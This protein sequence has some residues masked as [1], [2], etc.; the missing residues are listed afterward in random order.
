[1]LPRRTSA[2]LDTFVLATYSFDQGGS[3][4]TEG[5]V[6]V[7]ET[8]QQDTFFHVADAIELDGGDT[9]HLIVLEGTRSMWC[10]V[11]AAGQ[12]EYCSWVSLPGYGNSWRQTFSSLPFPRVS[13]VEFAYIIRW[14]VE[15]WEDRIYVEYRDENNAWVPLLAGPP[16]N[17]FYDKKGFAHE[18]WVLPDSVLG[19]SV[20]VRFRVTTDGA[21]SDEDGFEN[22]DGAVIIDSL[23]LKDDT[24]IIDFQNFEFEPVGAH[25]TNDGHWVAGFTVDPYGDFSG[26]YPG[27]TLLQEDPCFANISSVWAFIN[28]S[29]ADYGCG[30]HPE[31]TAVPFRNADGLYL[32]NEIW[33]PPIDW[34]EDELGIP[35]PSTAASARLEFDVYRDLPVDNLVFYSYAVR[36]IKEGCPDR[37]W[38]RISA[39]VG[40][41]EAKDWFRE[42]V[43]FGHL[44]DADADQIQVSLQAL[45]LCGWYCGIYGDGDCHSHAPLFDNVRVVR[46]DT[47][48]PVWTH[49]VWYSASLELFQDN[50][51][52]DGTTTG[53]VRIDAALDLFTVG[54]P[55]VLPGD[56]A[57][58]YV[59]HPGV[60]IDDHVPGDPQS[61]PAV[62]CHIRDVSPVKS[63]ATVSGSL[64]RWPVVVSSGGWTVLRCDFSY[65]QYGSKRDGQYCVDLNDSL[66]TPGDTIEYY[67]SARDANG[68]TNFWVESVGTVETEAE[69]RSASIEVTCLPANGLNGAT[70]ILYVDDFDG[71]GAQPYYDSAF[72]ALDIVPDRYDVRAPASLTGNGPGARV[73]D[74]LAQLGCYR[75]IIWNSG[76][77]ASGLIGDGTGSPEKSDDFGMLFEFLDQHP[78]GGGLYI[79]GDHICSEW[80][81]LTGAGAVDLRGTYLQFDVV[82]EDHVVLGQPVSPP[83][84]GEPGKCFDNPSGPDTLVVHGGC[85]AIN[86]FDVL[87][88]LGASEM[89]M[90]YSGQSSYGS[91]LTQV[92]PNS[93]GDTARVVVSG[94]SYHEIH[95]DRV[96]LPVDRVKHMLSILRWLDNE[97]DDPTDVGDVARYTNELGQNVPNPFNPKTRIS[98]SIREPSHVSLRI[99]NV[100]GQLVKTLVDDVETPRSRGF[101]VEWDGRNDSG[102]LVSSGVY[103]YRLVTKDYTQTRKMVVLK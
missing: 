103:F 7:D 82:G 32:G 70:D 28:G 34:T 39:M 16:W 98:Y 97:I 35:V 80:I 1:M 81:T 12:G 53:T 76:T 84:I 13:D 59:S 78:D 23:V 72:K 42:S 20:Q 45:D 11:D 85:P 30:G 21:W 27:E 24:G 102:E 87:E 64:D 73:V 3:P 14:D 15:P 67:F 31:Q 54:N 44:I 26:L 22:T 48:G 2:V 71:G 43:E 79:S 86:R 51:A 25:R 74:V 36:S 46:I 101:V 29:T 38:E 18:N 37:E 4:S 40:Y 68:N 58:V 90:S 33:S 61:G 41:G 99:Y 88:S 6:G 9:G 89:A 96:Q 62:Y 65:D 19:D 50:F 60:G 94:F 52:E 77:L 93:V 5:W 47:R 92:T 75:K 17:D 69:A 63:G 49:P 91:V 56:S 57:C 10:G 100:A 55:D 66:Y 95:D 83:V 8:S